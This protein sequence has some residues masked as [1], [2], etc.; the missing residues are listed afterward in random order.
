MTATLAVVLWLLGIFLMDALLSHDREPTSDAGRA[1]LAILR[2]F[3]PVAILS[4]A[5][6]CAVCFFVDRLSGDDESDSE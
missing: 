6:W 5:L 1:Q 4:M 2:V 3:W